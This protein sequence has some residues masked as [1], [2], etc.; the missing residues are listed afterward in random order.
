MCANP[1]TITSV[2]IDIVSRLRQARLLVFDLDGTLV[3]SRQDLANAVNATLIHF[4]RPALSLEVVANYVGNGAFALVQQ[5]FEHAGPDS[6][7]PQRLELAHQYFLDFYRQHRLDHT[8]AYPGVLEAL[9]SIRSHAP[10]TLIACLTNKPVVPSRA[11]CHGLG[12][13]PFFFQIYGGN[14]FATKKPDPLGLNQLIR[15]ANVLSLTGGDGH[16]VPIHAGNTVVI[17]DGLPD[18][19]VARAAGTQVIGC[20][21]GFSPTDFS[22]ARPDLCVTSPLDWIHLLCIV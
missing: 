3:D 21:F 7:D 5:A 13:A 15:E 14:S 16:G 18:I 6:S 1:L 12:L 10:H 2:S 22:L 20:S 11:I 4:G 19:L 8:Y 9:Q 17:G